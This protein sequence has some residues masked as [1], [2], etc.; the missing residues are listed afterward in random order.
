MMAF[1]ELYEEFYKNFWKEI[2]TI[3]SIQSE[4]LF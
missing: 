4:N 2:N 1:Q 3:S